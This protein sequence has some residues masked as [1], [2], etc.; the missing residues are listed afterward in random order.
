MVFRLPTLFLIF[1]GVSHVS[2]LSSQLKC[3]DGR[4]DVLTRP[5][6]R[7]LHLKIGACLLHSNDYISI[8]SRP[9]QCQEWTEKKILI[10]IHKMIPDNEKNISTFHQ[11]TCRALNPHP[12][13]LFWNKL[14]TRRV[15]F[16]A[17]FL[18][19]E[20]AAKYQSNIKQSI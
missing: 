16:F 4:T 19:P 14:D 13:P 6:Y 2:N 17:Q 18:T 20:R 7:K 15:E 11:S 3:F 12:L 9:P 1:T 10:K 5:K 8:N